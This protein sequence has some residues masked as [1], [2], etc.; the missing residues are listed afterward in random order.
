MQTGV[1]SPR[2]ELSP[3]GARNGSSVPPSPCEL[4]INT[5]LI[6]GDLRVMNIRSS[7]E[8]LP[9]MMEIT[10]H[11]LTLCKSGKNQP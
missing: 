7:P 6:F 11:S 4:V 1:M 2:R 9:W 5:Q 10:C 3:Q 8:I